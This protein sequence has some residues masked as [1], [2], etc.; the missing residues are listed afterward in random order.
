MF[1]SFQLGFRSACWKAGAKGHVIR[2]SDEPQGCFLQ[3]FNTSVQGCFLQLFDTSVRTATTTIA[4]ISPQSGTHCS[5]RAEKNGL[6]SE[7]M[8]VARLWQ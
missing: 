8:E 7:M 6:V 1:V 5:H 2:C 3:L 4:E